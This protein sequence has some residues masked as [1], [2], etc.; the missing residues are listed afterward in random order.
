VSANKRETLRQNVLFAAIVTCLSVTFFSRC[1]V[2][3][4]VIRICTRVVKNGK[5]RIHIR[6]L[7]R[8]QMDRRLNLLL[9][10]RLPVFLRLEALYLVTTKYL[11]PV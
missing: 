6:S 3:L 5:R 9:R 10:Q 11:Y 8:T 4:T 2:Q 7:R 1:V